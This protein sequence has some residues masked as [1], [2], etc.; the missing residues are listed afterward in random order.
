MLEGKKGAAAFNESIDGLTK[1]ATAAAIALAL[2]NPFGKVVGLLIAGVTAAVG[3]FAAY[4]KA[5][6]TMADQLYKTYSSLSKAGAGASDGMTGVLKASNQ[7]GLSMDE[8]GTFATQIAA[9]SKDLAL[10][11]GSVFEG[12]QKLGDMGDALR[13]NRQQFLA[14]G[15]GMTDVTEGML[16]YLRTQS[17]LGQSQLKTTDE[18]AAASPFVALI[19]STLARNRCSLSAASLSFSR[20]SLA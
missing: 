15:M 3:A 11:S 14:L 1:A 13:G 2:M 4:T 8:M 5:A 18:L 12:R 10:F 19:S 16:G 17:R 7:L 6:N 20:S 9:N